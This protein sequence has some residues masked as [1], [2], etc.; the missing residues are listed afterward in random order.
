LVANL[1]R[2]RRAWRDSKSSSR[3]NDVFDASARLPKGLVVPDTYVVLA[4]DILEM[5]SFDAK[6]SAI[7]LPWV[8]STQ[9]KFACTHIACTHIFHGCNDL[10]L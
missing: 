9:Q 6:H 10:A 1:A 2:H 8:I 5:W 3:A 4:L 7:R